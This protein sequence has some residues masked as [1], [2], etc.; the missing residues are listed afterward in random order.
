MR[1]R[2]WP[3]RLK[4][5][6]KKLLPP[7]VVDAVRSIQGL[8]Q[9]E[10]VVPELEVMSDSD[11]AWNSNQGWDHQSIAETQRKKWPLFLASVEGARALGWPHEALLSTSGAP[12]DL[13]THNNIMSFGYVLGRVAAEAKRPLRIL[14][15]GG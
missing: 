14:D 1:D 11:Q 4:Y 15:W 13:G 2:D 5:F 10:S 6:M 9:Q 12:I 7:I 8:L 3:T